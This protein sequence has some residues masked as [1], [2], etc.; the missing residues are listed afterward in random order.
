MLRLTRGIGESIIIGDDIKITVVEVTGEDG[1]KE[2]VLRV[3][4][5][6]FAPVEPST[7]IILARTQGSN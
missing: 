1:A 7:P 3:D 5:P 2:V 4:A 6:D